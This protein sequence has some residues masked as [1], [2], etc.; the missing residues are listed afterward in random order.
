MVEARVSPSYC[1]GWPYP[2]IIGPAEWRA[3]QE[4]CLFW[5]PDKPANSLDSPAGQNQNIAICGDMR[6]LGLPR[7]HKF[8]VTSGLG[9]GCAYYHKSFSAATL[10]G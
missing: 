5:S 6:S 7:C 4:T 10:S 2:K 8:S 3:E 1:P 9:F